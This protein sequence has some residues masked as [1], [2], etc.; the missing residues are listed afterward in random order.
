[1][2]NKQPSMGVEQKE[3]EKKKGR[4]GGLVEEIK[5]QVYHHI[6][7]HWANAQQ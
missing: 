2:L 6:S 3:E 4:E 5:I 1:M 7:L